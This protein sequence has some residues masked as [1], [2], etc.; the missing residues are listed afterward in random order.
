MPRL[1]FRIIGTGVWMASTAN[2]LVGFHPSDTP[3][4]SAPTGGGSERLFQFRDWGGG[5]AG[6]LAMGYVFSEVEGGFRIPTRDSSNRTFPTNLAGKHLELD[7]GGGVLLPGHTVEK[8]VKFTFFELDSSQRRSTLFEDTFHVPVHSIIT[9]A[10]GI[11]VDGVLNQRNLSSWFAQFD[12]N[13]VMRYS[14]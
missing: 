12:Y 5:G 8:D 2:V 7:Y 4:G 14:G 13:V 1:G 9:L 6:P 10:G 11:K 3:A